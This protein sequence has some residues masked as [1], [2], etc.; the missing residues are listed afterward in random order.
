MLH[1]TIRRKQKLKQTQIQQNDYF[2]HKLKDAPFR[3][4]TPRFLLG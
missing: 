1:Q 4:E 2:A 3:G